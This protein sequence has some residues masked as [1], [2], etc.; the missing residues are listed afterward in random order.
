MT[1][2]V[3]VGL[4]AAALCAVAWFAV[5]LREAKLAEPA[6][7]VAVGPASGLSPA[8]TAKADRDLSDAAGLLGHRDPT[9]FRAR[10]L[11]RTGHPARA[12]ALLRG[13]VRDEPDNATYWALLA[14]TASGSD[15]SLA[16]SARARLL[17]LDPRGTP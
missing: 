10:L 12:I 2:A 1:L 3:R 15:P 9:A 5:G 17:V 4:A 11:A 16:A 7:A 13:L 6:M 14:R 8:R